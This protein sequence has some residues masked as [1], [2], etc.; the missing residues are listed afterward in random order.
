M[1]SLVLAMIGARRAQAVTLFLLA[2]VAVA[3]AVA[4]PV[5]QRAVDEAIVRQEVAAASNTERSISV[6][7]FV[8][9][10][11]PQAA[12]QFD[13]LA[14]LL[15]LPG[16]DA[17][18]AGELEAF[19][20]LGGGG[21]VQLAPTSRVAFRDRLCEHVIILSGRCLI[22]SLEIVIGADMAASTA[23]RPGDVAVIQAARY[24]LG[25]GLVP[26]GEAAALTVVGI[27]QPRDATEAYWAGQSYFPITADGTRDETVFTTAVTF[28]II[29]HTLGQA[30]IDALAPASILTDER[31]ASLPDEIAT[32]TEPLLADPTYAVVTDLPALAERV[33]R[34]R[35]LAGQ[36]V[37]LAFIPLATISFFVIYLAVGSGVFGRR[38]EL[39]LV[40]L[41][42]VSS[43]RRWWLATGETALM[44]L[45][46]APVG[47]V[48][49]HLA[50]AAVAR[51]RLGASDGTTLN[52]A[53]LPYAGAALIAA[54]AVAFL[55]QRRAMRESV[56]DL[57]RGVPRSRTAWRSIVV[58]A[59]IGVLAVVATVQLRI[60]AD[61][62]S[63]VGLLVPGLVVVAV[64]VLAARAFV[65]IS[66]L[67]ARSALRS[68]R[69]AAGLSAVQLARRPGS[70]RLFVL[71]A[72]AAA[73]LGFVAAGT[74]VAAQAR[75]DRAL[76]ATGA[77]Q[78]LTV[79]EADARRLLTITRTVDPEGAWAMA[80]LEV[81]QPNLSDP[82]VLAVDSARLPAVAV[83]RPEFGAEVTALAT[84]LSPPAADPFVFRGSQ[85][86]LDV[87]TIRGQR[88]PALELGVEFVP[89]GG[90]DLISVS[91]ADLAVG[92]ETRQVG[93]NGCA[94]GCRLM[95][96]TVPTFRG[97]SV[98]LFVHGIRQAD[99]PADVVPA[100][101][102]IDRDR[103]R[104]TE[105]VQAVPFERSLSITVAGSNFFLSAVHV[106]AIDAPLPV[107]VA[108]AGDEP[109]QLT[110]V[111]TQTVLIRPVA[112]LP[113][114]PRLGARGVLVDLD[115]LERTVL[116]AVR[117]DR[118]EVWLG[119]NAPADAA[120]RL[121]KA[122]LAVSGQTGIQASRAALARQGP[123]LALQF[124]LA[125]ATFGILLA[126]GGLGLV[127]A[128]DRRQ[129]AADFRALRQQGLSRRTVGWAA[130][131]GYLAVVLLAAI[132][133]LLAAGV[134]WLAAGDRLPVFTDSLTLLDP[135]RWPAW[136]AVVLPWAVAVSSMVAAAFV[137]AWAL[138]RSTSNGRD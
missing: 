133:G 47:Y 56:V 45:A 79:D 67:V 54:L 64:A 111:D 17:I 86:L 27:Y 40:A 4:G 107:P 70:Q 37:P 78:V 34:S 30:S 94:E 11:Q 132:V 109:S 116:F 62:L 15:T 137:A 104:T 80:A 93:V 134:A 102:L 112:S 5:A 72:V 119:P 39:G 53:S 89:L 128:V 125:A 91:V 31:L 23:L 87:E 10:S 82:P 24:V 127:A 66:G 126:L 19:G 117:R 92:R 43:R 32:A 135:P 9:P 103:W 1:I 115:Y 106:A 49:G 118:G 138:R 2:A 12:G 33:A 100:T 59:L 25:R 55:G 124:H 29:D 26:D 81:P 95:G 16:F 14:E 76:V 60:A 110:S 69:L 113:L 85:L 42:G 41:R 48:L 51:L 84:A 21:D 28:D 96:L 74:D 73:M 20:P 68:G 35:D 13:T 52:L 22:G 130:V 46:G 121:R 63:G 36:L 8:N 114:L 38:T 108:T 58:E 6:T 65:P 136:A 131:W 98:R 101:E 61:G 3:A 83:W 57:L 123:A 97:G 129:R 71:L 88:D 90:G 120:E 99:P 122:G 75:D 44:I 50:V 77:I 18:R 105:L 7:A